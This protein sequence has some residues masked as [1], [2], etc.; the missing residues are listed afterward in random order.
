MTVTVLHL[1]FKKTEKVCLQRRQLGLQECLF[2]KVVQRQNHGMVADF[3]LR[4][5]A[6]ICCLTCRKI[7]KIG[8]QLQ[9]LQQM[10]YGHF[11]TGCFTCTMCCVHLQGS[12]ATQFR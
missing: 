12:A 3:I 6:D 11:L 5:G 4:L 2:Y 8:Q 1:S 10:L 7:I 9:K